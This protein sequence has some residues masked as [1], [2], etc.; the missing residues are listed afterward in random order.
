VKKL[1]N[2][3][4]IFL[5]MSGSLC[6]GVQKY[7]PDEI[8]AKTRDYIVK[9]NVKTSEKG[10]TV[11]FQTYLNDTL[12]ISPMQ[13]PAFMEAFGNNGLKPK[14]PKDKSATQA[15]SAPKTPAAQPAVNPQVVAI[16]QQLFASNID[17]NNRFAIIKAIK[18]AGH[19]T[20]DMGFVAA[21]ITRLQALESGTAQPQQQAPSA[22][23]NN[24]QQTASAP[25]SSATPPLPPPPPSNMKQPSQQ[26]AS[27]QQPQPSAN[28]RVD[29]INS[30]SFAKVLPAAPQQSKASPPAGSQAPPPPPPAPNQQKPKMGGLSV[31][32][33]LLFG[34]ISQKI[35][36]GKP[37]DY[38]EVSSYI[39]LHNKKALAP[40]V[41]YQQA[42]AWLS[43]HNPNTTAM[44][45]LNNNNASTQ[46]SPPAAS[47]TSASNISPKNS[48][49]QTLSPQA[50]AAFIQKINAA[51]SSNK[52]VSYEDLDKYF[53][54][55][56]KPN[57]TS[58]VKYAAYQW[59]QSN[60][61]GDVYD[62][63]AW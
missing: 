46:P 49:A 3:L 15:P 8:Y 7:T 59:L 57:P 26:P 13:T 40:S 47:N 61:P 62:G 6:Y 44:F 10:A 25:T 1:H 50:Q 4:F 30:L 31:Q 2:K 43:S 22:S 21:V 12:G 48:N 9:N 36:Q 20:S 38:G 39:D 28:S 51:L 14:Q 42:L 63:D 34:I 23:S 37:I 52:D 11:A 18:Q 24:N 56:G 29:L 27:N 53:T 41:E 19:D 32:E 17:S 33:D 45:T 5:A 55:Q 60:G 16:A 54:L 58:K 35:A